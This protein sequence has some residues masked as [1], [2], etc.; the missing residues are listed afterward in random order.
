VNKRIWGESVSELID[1]L[2]PSGLRTGEVLPLPEIHR[3][4]KHHR[5]VHIYLFNSREEL[6]IQKR[7]PTVEFFP[8]YWGIS[9]TG[10]IRSGESSSAAA[11]RELDEELGIALATG[12]LE[13]QFSYLQE[14]KFREAYLDRQ[15]NDVYIA[16]L[17]AQPDRIQLDPAEVAGVRFVSFDEFYHMAL[18]AASGLVPVYASECRD[19]AYFLAGWPRR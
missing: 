2:S 9:V 17:D 15:F 13:F 10:H 4:G 1:V 5:A 11:S 16:R 12:P 19:L 6:L 7:A 3:L 14:F 8:G 18:D